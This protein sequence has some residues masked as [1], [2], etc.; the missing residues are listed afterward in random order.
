MYERS[1]MHR[2]TVTHAVMASQTEFLITASADGHIKF[3]KKR[4]KGIEFAKHFRAHV[5]PVKGKLTLC[6]LA[7]PGQGTWRGST[8]CDVCL[9]ASSHDAY[10][11]L[12]ALTRER[13][14]SADLALSHDGSMLVSIADDRSIKIFDVANIDM[15][16]M[17]R[18]S[19]LPAC[20]S[21]IFKVSGW[22]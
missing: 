14:C 3:W 8:Y 10:L 1:Y 16:A 2:D 15:M 22:T 6:Q 20:A 4:A 19:F 7:F 11:C 9:L 12:D 5:G 13:P 21:W 17:L 18:L